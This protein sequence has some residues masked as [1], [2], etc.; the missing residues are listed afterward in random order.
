MA[1]RHRD[2]TGLRE[3]KHNNTKIETL[4]KKY[5]GFAEGEI[6]SDATLGTLK[7]KLG[8][9]QSASLNDVRQELKKAAK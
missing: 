5:P 3:R 1:P 7:D 4:R 8:L 9:A 2:V 6:R